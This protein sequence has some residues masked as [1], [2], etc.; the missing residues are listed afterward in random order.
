VVEEERTARAEF[1]V[2]SLLR[3]FRSCQRLRPATF[4]FGCKGLAVRRDVKF[5][6]PEVCKSSP[7]VDCEFP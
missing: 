1:I 7:F 4:D 2:Y 6:T 5:A 3:T